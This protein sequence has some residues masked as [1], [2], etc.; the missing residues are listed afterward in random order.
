MSIGTPAGRSSI[1]PCNS[2]PPEPGLPPEVATV[3][4]DG[5]GDLDVVFGSETGTT[6]W[7]ENLGGLTFGAPQELTSTP[8]RSD[9]LVET[10]DVDGDGRD[11]LVLAA[12]DAGAVWLRGVPGG[13]ETRPRPITAGIGGAV[14]LLAEDFD[15]DGDPD[16]VLGN[17]DGGLSVVWNRGPGR[18]DLPRAAAPGVAVPTDLAATD[19]DLDGDPDVVVLKAGGELAWS[20]VDGLQFG[21]P[22]PIATLPPSAAFV[23]AEDVDQD[24]DD[25]I[26]VARSDGEVLVVELTAP[27]TYAAPRIA[28]A[29]VSSLTDIEVAD[30]DADGVADLAVSAVVAGPGRRTAWAAGL[31]DGT[32]SPWSVL[33]GTGDATGID[34]EDVD[35]DGRIDLTFT[36]AG[37][38]VLGWVENL[39]PGSF[40]L[41]VLQAAFQGTPGDVDLAPLD[42]N[43]GIDALVP[44]IQAQ[45]RGVLV[46]A[47]GTSGGPLV[48]ERELARF[49]SEVGSIVSADLD[50]DGDLD[51]VVSTAAPSELF[52]LE[53]RTVSEVGVSYCGPSVTNSIGR[54]ASILAFG[55]PRA[56]SGDLELIALDLPSGATCVFL[57]APSSGLVPQPPGSVGTL[58]L[59]SSIGRYV[60]AGQFGA[61]DAGGTLR[62]TFSLAVIPGP[63]GPVVPAPGDLWY[64]QA[65]YR[66]VT[67]T[68]VASNFTDGVAIRLE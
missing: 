37:P 47:T 21:P 46:A 32:F 13:F 62:R 29:A 42:G 16:L 24:G 22:Q 17:A 34:L 67:T 48:G 2:A 41:P 68:G 38:R 64:F 33:D 18:L 44:L 54:S 3:D 52:Y 1:R 8:T 51:V 26:L 45:G 63:A 57:A 6:S 43:A 50:G 40:A 27:S 7:I 53:N 20:E 59:G 10:A 49:V 9:G 15:L 14:G 31:G 61:A 23:R 5:D 58:C 66:D 60:G 19:V 56:V 39:S 11:D 30:L 4:V 28:T 65:W 25:D 12:R 35:G 55:T 36:S